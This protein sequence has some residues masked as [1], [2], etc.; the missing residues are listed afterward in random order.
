MGI[1]DE[2]MQRA[3]FLDRD[4]VINRA[5]IRQGKPYPPRDAGELE[6]LPGVPDSLVRLQQAGFECIVVTNQPDVARGTASRDQ[7]E[8]INEQL[9]KELAID[10][11]YVCWHDDA[12]GCECRKPL[13]GLLLA[14]ARERNLDL[15]ASF[16]VGDRW[17]DVEAGQ[18]AGCRTVWI[19]RQYDEKAPVG[20]DYETDGLP[21][22]VDWILGIKGNIDAKRG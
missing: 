13:A 20:A 18:R 22:A 1:D 17:R 3:A 4:G 16:M 9:R 19:N 14:A 10:A 15:K 7:V 12:D 11:F 8:A 6:V 21:A 5:Y 2:V